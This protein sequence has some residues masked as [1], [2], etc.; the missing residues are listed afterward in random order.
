[1]T[2]LMEK[3]TDFELDFDYGKI[4]KKVVLKSLE[5]ENCPYECEVNITL[6]DDKDINAIQ[7]MLIL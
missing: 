7:K 2:I 5:F 6:A 4:L 3:E 1:M